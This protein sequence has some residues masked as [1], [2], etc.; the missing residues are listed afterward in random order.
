MNSYHYLPTPFYSQSIVNSPS[1]NRKPSFSAPSPSQ[2]FPSHTG[3]VFFTL[4]YTGAILTDFTKS[5]LPYLRKTLLKHTFHQTMPPAQK[6]SAIP[7]PHW[8][9]NRTKILKPGTEGLFPDPPTSVVNYLTSL[10]LHYS[11]KNRGFW[12]QP[13]KH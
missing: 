2:A 5:F 8:Q 4:V 9:P 11:F 6:S 7:S 12:Y 1:I 3:P 13:L 10:S